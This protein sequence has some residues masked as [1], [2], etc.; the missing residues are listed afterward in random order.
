MIAFFSVPLRPE[1]GPWFWE[2]DTIPQAAVQAI[3]CLVS[4]RKKARGLGF[5]TEKSLE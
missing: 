3:H 4:K 2:E 1:L 5:G